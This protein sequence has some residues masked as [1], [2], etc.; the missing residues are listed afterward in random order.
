MRTIPTEMARYAR[1]P[2]AD[3]QRDGRSAGA[4]GPLEPASAIG[5]KLSPDQLEQLAQDCEA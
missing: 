2:Q 3:L 1:W 4:A 5:D